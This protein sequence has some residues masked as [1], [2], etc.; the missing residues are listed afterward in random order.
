MLHAPVDDSTTVTVR[1]WDQQV[2]KAYAVSFDEFERANPDIEVEVTVVPWA[3]YFTLL[4]TDIASGRI[5]D[6]FWANAGNFEE[7]AR[8]G[9]LRDISALPGIDTGGWAPTVVEQYTLDG[10]LWGVPQLMDLGIGVLYNKE[11][12]EGADVPV[13]EVE[14][15]TWDPAAPDDSLRDVAARLTIDTAGR[16]PDDPTFD[17][18][19]VE[20]YGYSASND[21]NAITINFIGSNGGA[22]Q[23]GDE[24]VFDSP[25]AVEAVRYVVDL[26]NHDH[27]ALPAADTNPPG[28]GEV[29]LAQF[30]QGRLALLQTGAYNL[31]NVL[32]DATFEWGVASLPTGPAGAVS[33][34]KGIVA[35]ASADSPHP[36]AQAKVLAWLGSA[37][38]SRHIG[39]TGSALP[40]VLGAQDAYFAF[41]NAEGVDLSPMTDV[42]HNGTVQAPRGARYAAAEQ[43]YLPI[44]NEIYLGRRPVAEGLAAAAHAANAAVENSH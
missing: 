34:T 23:R 7:Y 30:L 42:L 26:I 15:L 32:D 22:W 20:R 16:T 13:S 21:L 41:W 24:F 29:A 17:P 4:R 39:E 27:I 28:G 10:S 2:A 19:R 33:V 9:A 44:F 18:L 8:N 43:A 38:G 1:L 3:D 31:V 12:L 25:E 6:V 36:A 40:A 14:R 11:L 5:D 35:A 37:A